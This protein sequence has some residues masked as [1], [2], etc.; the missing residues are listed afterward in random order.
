[1]VCL[2]TSVLAAY[3]CQ[4]KNSKIIEEIITQTY[5]PAISQLAE[6]E[7]VSAI[8]RKIRENNL[9]QKDGKRILA[10]FQEHLDKGFYFWIPIENQHYKLA[11]TWISQSS[12]SLRTLDALHLAVAS[13]NKLTI[14][15]ADIQLV[16]AAE[17]FRV[18]VKLI[19]KGVI[20]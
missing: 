5:Q 8:S 7:L 19:G 1:M 11:K 13:A 14:I 9:S 4:E 18:N 16:R 3:Y 12:T 2:D 17:L 6:V 10:Q 20:L 15:T